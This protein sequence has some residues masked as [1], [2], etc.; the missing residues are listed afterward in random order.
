VAVDYNGKVISGYRRF[1]PY[2]LTRP[3]GYGRSKKHKTLT[4]GYEL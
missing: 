3:D 1:L 2:Q 4:E